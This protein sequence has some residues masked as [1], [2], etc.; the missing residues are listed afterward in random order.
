MTIKWVKVI[1]QNVTSCFFSQQFSA[2][3][4]Y[5]FATF[6]ISDCGC[7]CIQCVAG[8]M[9]IMCHSFSLKMY[10]H[11]FKFIK[12][13]TVSWQTW[14]MFNSDRRPLSL[15]NVWFN[16]LIRW[17]LG[18]VAQPDIKTLVFFFFLFPTYWNS[19]VLI[20]QLCSTSLFA[21]QSAAV[22]GPLIKFIMSGGNWKHAF[23][24]P[25]HTWLAF[26]WTHYF[27]HRNSS[28]PESRSAGEPLGWP[29]PDP[30]Q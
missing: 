10:F 5:S 20:Y 19:A 18:P 1:K 3:L 12:S 28:L 7:H 22:W 21:H 15:I 8:I 16:I 6:Y 27:P 2:L 23:S 17:S 4:H 9:W 25:W 13:K 29:T 14:Q 11:H 24:S 26:A 30:I